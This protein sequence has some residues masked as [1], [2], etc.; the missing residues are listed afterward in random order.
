MINYSEKYERVT[1]EKVAVD[2]RIDFLKENEIIKEYFKLLDEKNELENEQKELFKKMKFQEY[3]NCSHIWVT[4][5]VDY[6]K[7]E[8]RSYRYCGCIKCGLD[9]Q[10]YNLIENIGLAHLNPLNRIMYDYMSKH[11]GYEFIG[12]QIDIYC[13]LNIASI[14]YNEIKKEL[15]D[16]D[17]DTLIKHFE[18][19]YSGIKEITKN[20]N[21][22]Q[23][24]ISNYTVNVLKKIKK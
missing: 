8:G 10:T 13:D 11:Y 12:K 22:K 24:D 17:D 18:K 4:T 7:G 14:I 20:N 9:Q 1:A 16:I 2:K 6:D 15:P 21:I 23:K 5:L 19:V 3:S